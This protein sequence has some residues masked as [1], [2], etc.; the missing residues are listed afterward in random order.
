M[1]EQDEYTREE[2]VFELFDR[3]KHDKKY[4]PIVKGLAEK[5]DAECRDA[6]V[7]WNRHVKEMRR[8]HAR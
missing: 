5:G 7:L 1:L 4:R 3:M 8:L 2:Y 6:M